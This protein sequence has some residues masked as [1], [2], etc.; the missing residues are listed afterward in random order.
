MD[1]SQK[2]IAAVLA[3]FFIIALL[4]VFSAPLRVALRLLVN[5][6][7]GFLALW[8]VQL[9]AGFTGIALG[10]NLWNALVVGV[11]GVPGFVL[12]LLVQ[13]VL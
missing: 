9:T 7:L 1:L 6:L 8:V 12:L 4:R 2:I 13:W 10:M 3:G 11:L 5:T